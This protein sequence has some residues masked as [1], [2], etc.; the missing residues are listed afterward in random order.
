MSKIMILLYN[1]LASKEAD[2]SCAFCTLT[3]QLLFT[4]STVVCQKVYLIRLF[5]AGESSEHEETSPDN[6]CWHDTKYRYKS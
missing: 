1:S 6:Q 4:S 3:R 2:V 5:A